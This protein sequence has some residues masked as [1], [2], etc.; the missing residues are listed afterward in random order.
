MISSEGLLKVQE[1][2]TSE[3]SFAKNNLV[4]EIRNITETP[5]KNILAFSRE[6]GI[7]QFNNGNFVK[8]P[9]QLYQNN[10]YARNDFLDSY[11]TDDRNRQWWATRENRLFCFDNGKLIDYSSPRIPVTDYLAWISYNAITKKLFASQDTL[12]TIK[13]LK[14]EIFQPTNNKSQLLLLLFIV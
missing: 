11:T 4:T 3:F 9:V 14:I 5:D 8:A 6:N 1:Q 2:N 13:D 7:L 12:K 10:K